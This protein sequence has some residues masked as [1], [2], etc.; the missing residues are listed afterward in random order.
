MRPKSW[1][2]TDNGGEDVALAHHASHLVLDDLRVDRK[3]SYVVLRA[4]AIRLTDGRS[5]ERRDE[6][7]RTFR[8][9][10]LSSSNRSLDEHARLAGLSMDV[11]QAALRG[12]LIDVPLVNGRTEL[13]EVLHGRPSARDLIELMCDIA[14]ENA[15]VPAVE[16]V[17]RLQQRL[18]A[19]GEALRQALTTA[20][21]FYETGAGAAFEDV[22]GYDLTRVHGRFAT[23]Y[24]AGRPRYRLGAA[25]VE[26]S[27]P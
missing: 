1:H 8:T 24:A 11:D 22:P 4:Y 10:I 18:C 15:G 3:H 26:S 12:R 13:F 20:R 6:P 23:I 19:D 16:F 27:P 25:A 9:P 7:G 17:A 14:K 2:A 21:A 5:K